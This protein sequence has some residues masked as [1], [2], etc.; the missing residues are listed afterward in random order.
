ME[1]GILSSIC[2]HALGVFEKVFRLVRE[3]LRWGSVWQAGC[4]VGV[5]SQLVR[6]AWSL[7][8]NAIAPLRAV[9]TSGGLDLQ[10]TSPHLLGFLLCLCFILPFLALFCCSCPF[11]TP[12]LFLLSL[13][14]SECN[15]LLISQKQPLK[16]MKN[17]LEVHLNFFFF[18]FTA[19]VPARN[20]CCC[21]KQKPWKLYPAGNFPFV[22][23][24][25]SLTGWSPALL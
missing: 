22:L 20:Y 4:S 18:F 1:G 21:F 2:L 25:G 9:C 23:W 3:E 17:L 16:P 10:S 14:S 6:R 12:H 11:Q 15:T 7:L 24:S 19:S 13:L 5:L 8:L